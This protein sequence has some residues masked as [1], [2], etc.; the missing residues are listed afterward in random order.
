L[1]LL[2]TIVDCLPPLAARALSVIV[3]FADASIFVS[4]TAMAI[5]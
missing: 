4:M 3:K 1:S 2:V 5:L